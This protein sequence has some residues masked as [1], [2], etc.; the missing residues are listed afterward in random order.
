MADIGIVRNRLKIESTISNAQAWLKMMDEKPGGFSKFVW[1]S[2]D[3]KT[4]INQPQSMADV[5]GKTPA[6]EALSKRLKKAGF[7]F[8]GPTICY[9]FMQSMGLVDD[10][11]VGC[12]KKG[13]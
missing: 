8:V 10:H 3:G 11:M 2:V 1:D 12:W 9:A 5:P 13:A 4:L 6:A 7:R